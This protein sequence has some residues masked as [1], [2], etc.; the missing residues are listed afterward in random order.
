MTE[1]WKG[2]LVFNKILQEMARI[3]KDKA[4]HFIWGSVIA[5]AGAVFGGVVVGAV[6]AFLVGVLKEVYDYYTYRDFDIE[7]ILFTLSGAVVALAPAVVL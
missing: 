1:W 6:L 2:K 5:S 3:P 4:L 7:D